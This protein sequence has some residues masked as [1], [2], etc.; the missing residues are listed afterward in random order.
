M[1]RYLPYPS[2]L[3]FLCTTSLPTPPDRLVFYCPSVL[4]PEAEPGGAVS[5]TLTGEGKK[6]KRPVSFFHASLMK[7]LDEEKSGPAL[8][9]GVQKHGRSLNMQEEDVVLDT[10]GTCFRDMPFMEVTIVPC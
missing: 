6:G 1:T 5:D 7:D 8:S 2:L 4:L 9:A 3:I 10:A